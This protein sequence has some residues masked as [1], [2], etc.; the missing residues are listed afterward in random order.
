MSLS[1][2][3]W[4]LE[5][6]INASAEALANSVNQN[7]LSSG[8][9]FPDVTRLGEVSSQVAAAVIRCAIEEKRCEP[10]E[11]H[12]IAELISNNIWTPNYADYIAV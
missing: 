11:E 10:L 12:E 1:F 7:E 5:G 3:A 2:Q 8:M 6:M 4:V 9:L